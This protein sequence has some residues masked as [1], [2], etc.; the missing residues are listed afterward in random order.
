MN[1]QVIFSNISVY[2]LTHTLI[3]ATCIGTLFAIVSQSQLEVNPYLLIL[4]YNG[5][6]FS[7][8][9]LFGLLVDKINLPKISTLAG[10]ILVGTSPIL[11]QF[12][13]PAILLAGLGNALF[14]VGG[15][16][17]I[18]NLSNGKAAMPGIFVAPGALGLTIGVLLGKSGN[19]IAGPFLI[20]LLCAALLVLKIPTVEIHAHREY[21]E[22]LKW[23]EAVI[24]L[25][26]VSISIRSMVGL[27][28]VFPWKTDLTLLYV[29]TGAIVAGKA[30]GGVLGDRYGWTFVAVT[31]LAASIPLLTFFPHIP[32][33]AIFGI[34]LFNLSMPITLTCLARMMPGKNGFAFGLTTLALFIG[35][36]P[37]FFNFPSGQVVQW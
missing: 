7:T 33:L 34:F 27:G 23:F 32:I 9:P 18:L 19:F 24:M 29:L 3:D 20:M 8:Q 2:S 22:N 1:K 30:L 35:A 31:G 17:T 5:L 13:F 11:M 37:S 16:V 10:I 15:G 26:L 28:L 12:P 4:F 36:L 14:H 25:L 21:S 6:A